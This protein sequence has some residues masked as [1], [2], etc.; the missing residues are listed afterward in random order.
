MAKP[1][2]QKN[3]L[4]LVIIIVS[5]LILAFTLLGKFFE[6]GVPAEP[7]VDSRQT[8]QFE[9]VGIDFGELQLKK[10][11]DRWT[12]LP[13]GSLDQKQLELITSQW[14]LLLNK[15]VQEPRTDGAVSIQSASTVLLYLKGETRPIIC[16]VVLAETQTYVEFLASGQKIAVTLSFAKSLLPNKTT[17]ANHSNEKAQTKDELNNA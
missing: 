17:S 3:W 5:G 12:L 16:K 4:N 1:N 6:S 2:P 9:L 7:A 13:K 8:Q 14:D 10:N 15:D 11:S